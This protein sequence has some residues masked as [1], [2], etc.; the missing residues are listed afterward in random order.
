MLGDELVLRTGPERVLKNPKAVS[1][2]AMGLRPLRENT[3]KVFAWYDSEFDDLVRACFFRFL[4]ISSGEPRLKAVE[5]F[6]R[7]GCAP[8]S[9]AV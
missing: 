3:Y 5:E 7:P 8:I 1:G 2:P 4:V 6:T 9:G